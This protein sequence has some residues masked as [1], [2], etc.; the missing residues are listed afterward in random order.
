VNLHAEH[1]LTFTR[2][3]LLPRLAANLPQ[4]STPNTLLQFFDILD[5]NESRQAVAYVRQDRRKAA[6]QT[7][8]IIVGY[9]PSSEREP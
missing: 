6:M 2:L 7:A 1:L 4:S 9:P 3:R 8:D 5:A